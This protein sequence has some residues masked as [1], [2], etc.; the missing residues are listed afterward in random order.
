[1]A[2]LIWIDLHTLLVEVDGMDASK[3]YFWR[4]FK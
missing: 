1:M 2:I 4:T 3:D